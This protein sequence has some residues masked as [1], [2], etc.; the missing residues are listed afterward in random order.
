M[1]KHSENLI[2][3]S[4]DGDRFQLSARCGECS[5]MGRILVSGVAYDDC[6]ACNGLGWFGIDP[7]MPVMAHVGSAAKVAMLTVRYASG[8]PLWHAG[9]GYEID[10]R[11][12]NLPDN[13]L[14]ARP[15][16]SA[17]PAARRDGNN[18]NRHVTRLAP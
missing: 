9:D 11:S 15:A 3:W 5:G 2:V 8:V 14:A 7:Q 1:T 12:Q 16:T 13:D 6:G 17:E 10:L 4:Q 18:T